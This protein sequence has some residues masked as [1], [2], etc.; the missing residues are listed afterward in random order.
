MMV[1]ASFQR[2]DIV[3]WSWLMPPYRWQADARVT[4]AVDA[5]V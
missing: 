4:E 2:E 5:I 3:G 1:L